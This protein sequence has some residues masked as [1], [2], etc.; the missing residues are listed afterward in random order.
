MKQVLF[1]LATLLP[2]TAA[3]DVFDVSISVIEKGVS[4][5]SNSSSFYPFD[6][7]QSASFT[8]NG[9]EK[10]LK[11]SPILSTKT[12]DG[13]LTSSLMAFVTESNEFNVIYSSGS[14]GSVEIKTAWSGVDSSQ[15]KTTSK[16]CRLSIQIEER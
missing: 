7:G 10:K 1:A 12:D 6:R 16:G 4:I 15:E 3:A 13:K 9:S 2:F 14:C 5:D 8:H 11:Y